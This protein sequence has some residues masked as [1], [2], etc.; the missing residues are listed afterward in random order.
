MYNQSLILRS[1]ILFRTILSISLVILS[2]GSALALHE[3]G[4][5]RLRVR[6]PKGGA[7]AAS[8]Q[9]VCEV[10]Q[11]HRKF[12]TKQDG[13]YFAQELPFGTY[14]LEVSH[15]GFASAS[16]LIQIRSE[17]PVMIS[18]TLGLVPV[19]TSVD[20]TDSSTLVDTEGARTVYSAGRKTLSQ[21]IPSQI[22]RG[23]SN[24][25]NSEAGWLYEANGVLHPRGS[26]YDVQFVV[27][28]LPVTENRSPAFAPS[29]GSGDAQSIRVMT[30]GFPAE[31][32]RKLGGVVEVTTQKDLPA[33]F[34]MSAA[35]GGGSF[36]TGSGNIQIGYARGAN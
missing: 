5:V 18:V 6:D 10:N 1:K 35:V 26:E 33:G 29:L 13:G 9:L 8:V 23:L 21:Q 31:Y 22:G 7:L 20:V 4:A 3:Q 32:G 36:S 15:P 25:V 24:A 19:R 27:N 30:A 12:M 17:V 28:G 34:H 16:R 14:S 11:V 2:V